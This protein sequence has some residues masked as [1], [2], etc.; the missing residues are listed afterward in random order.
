MS[1]STPDLLSAVGN[2]T[3]EYY[4]PALQAAP[5]RHS[6]GQRESSSP[7]DSNGKSSA[8]AAAAASLRLSLDSLHLTNG[9]NQGGRTS[10][11]Q[12]QEHSG[13][14]S[15]YT[16]SIL[17]SALDVDTGYDFGPPDSTYSLFDMNGD[18]G[19]C[20][21][22][23]QSFSGAS[24]Q[25]DF[26]E[27]LQ[28]HAPRR[29]SNTQSSGVG[30]FGIDWGNNGL[31]QQQQQIQQPKLPQHLNMQAPQHHQ[32]Q[33]HQ[34]TLQMNHYQ[35]PQNHLPQQHYQQQQQMPHQRGSPRSSR[36][37]PVAAAAAAADKPRGQGYRKLW[38][39]VRSC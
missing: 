20:S 27:P 8:A 18:A 26:L 2:G 13:A 38:Q 11:G 14:L 10:G 39:Q 6:T 35:Q 24:G 33:H 1:S 4:V 22:G 9:D 32:P 36:P 29:S 5:K 21:S 37:N 3:S 12:Y 31:M 28:R 25:A 19:G 16:G 34:P 23:Q 7:K 30:G 17:D 15:C